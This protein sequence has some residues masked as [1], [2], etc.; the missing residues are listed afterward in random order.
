MHTDRHKTLLQNIQKVVA[1]EMYKELLALRRRM[2]KLEAARD[3]WKVTALRYRQQL[4][5]E[6]NKTR[7]TPRNRL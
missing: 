2:N 6:L 3:N 7:T 4:I 1:P 5:D